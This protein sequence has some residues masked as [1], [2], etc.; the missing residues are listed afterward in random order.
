MHRAGARETTAKVLS[1]RGKTLG[2]VE[3][4]RRQWCVK[5]A[6]NKILRNLVSHDQEFGLFLRLMAEDEL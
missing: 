3:V 6:S 2:R 1:N 4:A 5:L